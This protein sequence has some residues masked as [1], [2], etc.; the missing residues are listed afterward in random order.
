MFFSSNS[1]EH[2]IFSVNLLRWENL[3]FLVGSESEVSAQARVDL[4]PGV[5]HGPLIAHIYVLL[6]RILLDIALRAA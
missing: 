5:S 3:P 4:L 2:H 1:K 6:A